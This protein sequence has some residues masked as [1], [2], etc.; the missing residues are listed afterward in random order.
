MKSPRLI[1]WV[2]AALLILAGLWL[3]ARKPSSPKSK[4]EFSP[5]VSTEPARPATEKPAKPP[6]EA[7]QQKPRAFLVELKE[8]NKDDFKENLFVMEPSDTPPPFQLQEGRL[9][10]REEALRSIAEGKEKEQFQLFL[11]K[12]G[13]DIE[14]EA[15]LFLVHQVQYQGTGRE[16]SFAH[17]YIFS[18]YPA[19]LKLPVYEKP[20]ESVALG[21]NQSAAQT[22]QIRLI[23]AETLQLSEKE[24]DQIEVVFAGRKTIVLAEGDQMLS[25]LSHATSV[26]QEVFAPLPK[27]EVRQ[28]DFKI[29]TEEYGK[30]D[31][32]TELSVKNAGLHDIQLEKELPP[33]SESEE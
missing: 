11:D 31:F 18:Q 10:V 14:K 32:Q 9:L 13:M 33:A 1:L 17:Y 25:K 5:P 26:T 8:I 15:K 22:F 16:G 30:V 7:S 29:L 6:T 20:P 2:A 4:K 24:P 27:G 3:F 28:E 19:Q 21:V 12:P 23:P